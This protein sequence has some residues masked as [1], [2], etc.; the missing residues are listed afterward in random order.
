MIEVYCDESRQDLMINKD[1][2]SETN[3]FI[4]IGAIFLNSDDRLKIK[5]KIL[6]AKKKYNHDLKKEIKRNKVTYKYL[7]L[8]KEIIDIYIDNN[9]DFRTICIDSNKV[10]LSFHNNDAELGFYK[11]YYLLLNGW[12]TNNKKY[13]IYTDLKSTKS[14]NP[15]NT[16]KR[17]LNNSNHPFSV[18]KLYAIES[19]QSVFLQMEDIIMG[20][21]AYK[22]NLGNN[23]KSKAKVELVN[24]LENK[25]GHEIKH[26]DKSTKKFNLFE[27]RI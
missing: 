4:F 14:A 24:Y 13:I 20:A 27:I 9:I 11:F 22:M 2:I 10:D 6:Q 16:L 26:T 15:L 7:E 18:E 17:C 21:A 23:G 25:L 3:K 19:S 8:Y 5:N 1:V 12:I